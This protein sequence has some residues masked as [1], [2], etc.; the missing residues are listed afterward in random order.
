MGYIVNRGTKDCPKWYAKFKDT[1]G[2]WK[3]KATHQTTRAAA[4]RYVAELDARV[5]RG[6]VGIPEPTEQE[7]TA[8]TLTVA[9][10]CESFLEKYNR[11][12]IKDIAAYR[13]H[14]RAI[15][16]QELL[17]FPIASMI[18]A[19]VR[20][21]DVQRWR[22][23]LCEE[24][25][26]DHTVNRA[27]AVLSA[28]YSWA[29]MEEILTTRNPC[30]KVERMR[31]K[32]SEDHYSMEEIHRLLSLPDVPVML[33]TALYAGMRKGELFG[34]TW[35]CV[36][37]DGAVPYIDVRKS[38]RGATKSGKPRAVPIHPELMPILRA[39][40]KIC[41]ATS[42]GLVYPV[43]VVNQRGRHLGGYRMGTGKDMEGIRDLLTAAR[44]HA[45]DDPWHA[46]RHTFGTCFL[47]ASGNGD[48]LS[49]LFG[50]SGGS[51]AATVTMGYTHTGLAYL[52]R[53]LA[54]M[55]LVPQAPVDEIKGR[56][57][58][59]AIDHP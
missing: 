23:A 54:K 31:V 15:V 40:Q 4:L 20:P 51:G 50:H 44:C 53:E 17:R 13:R 7:T 2:K 1:D 28:A 11:P 55:T 26:S 21:L 43:K 42:E 46:F 48:A 3:Q 19:E 5:S 6:L 59:E 41:P 45:P 8:R 14:T 9:A 35:P 56:E 32:P 57:T 47:E 22:D 29:Q 38:Y 24:K 25:Y 16:N 10:M 37:L 36:R 33:V 18:A 39:W 12:R 27:I 34:L 52:Q 30:S 49:K 58:A